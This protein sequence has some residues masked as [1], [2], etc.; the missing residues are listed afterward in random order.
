[1]TQRFNAL[2]RR[3]RRDTSGSVKLEFVLVVPLFLSFLLFSIELG[4]ITLRSTLLSRGLDMTVREIRLTTGAEWTH[5]EIKEKVCA[6]AGLLREC[7]SMLR[8]EMRRKSIREYSSL[9]DDVDC[10]DR[11]EETHPV[12]F[13]SGGANE[14]MVL[15]ACYKFDPFW[16][17]AFMGEQLE[18]DSSG[19][20][21][22]VA[23]TA[24]VQEPR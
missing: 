13:Q 7:D 16:N 18:L 12:M 11:A 22:I 23:M 5:D 19:D 4:F 2:L 10:T 24:F 17:N 14:L 6:N 20:A 1:M 3:F 8:L 15:R 9:G 21:S